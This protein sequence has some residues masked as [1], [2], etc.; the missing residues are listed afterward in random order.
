MDARSSAAAWLRGQAGAIEAKAERAAREQVSAARRE[1]VEKVSREAEQRVSRERKRAELEAD[2]RIRTEVA[3]ARREIVAE[4]ERRVAERERELAEKPAEPPEQEREVARYREL[5]GRIGSVR[6]PA[7]Q[8]QA[9]APGVERK[10]SESRDEKR[11]KRRAKGEQRKAERAR[12]RSERK[13][14]AKP[15]E[16]DLPMVDVN[17]ATFEQLRRLGLSVTQATRVIAY[18]QRQDGF[19][20]V[21]E[22]DTVPGFPKSFLE[23]LKDRLSA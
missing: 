6:Q 19:D 15:P 2:G 23:E 7:A 10:P 20:S 3:R 11:A 22:L 9:K 18:R 21:D 14:A 4:A 12:A 13:Q 5:R 1:A 17:E 16:P 8:A